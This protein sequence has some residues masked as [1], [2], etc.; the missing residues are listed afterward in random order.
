MKEDLS[1]GSIFGALLE[2]KT[3]VSGLPG[4]LNRVLEN[5]GSPE[6]QVTIK[7]TESDRLIEAM[8]KIANRISAGIVLAALILGAALLMRVETSFRVLGYPGLAMICFA[9][10][11][12]GG[13]WLVIST[14]L[15]DRAG[16]RTK[17]R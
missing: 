4:R 5:F 15:A 9:A 14:F 6:F 2:M 12:G 17:L 11:A 13:A 16:K 10:A 1:Q 3:F 8:Q 7:S